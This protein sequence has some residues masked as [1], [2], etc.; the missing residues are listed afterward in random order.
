MVAQPDL[1]A[2]EGQLPPEDFAAARQAAATV[3]LE[4]LVAA[5]RRDLAR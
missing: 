3:V 5:V 1:D 4:E 2:L